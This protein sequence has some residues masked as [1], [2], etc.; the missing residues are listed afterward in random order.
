MSLA[1]E[2]FDW[3]GGRYGGEPNLSNS[4]PGRKG[5]GPRRESEEELGAQRREKNQP[6]M[7]GGWL[8]EKIRS[9]NYY[10]MMSDLS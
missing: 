2:E 4:T 9:P 6:F 5:W 3:L 1:L 7:P 8:K 10:L